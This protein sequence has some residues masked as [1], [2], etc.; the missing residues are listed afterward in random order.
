MILVFGTLCLDRVR[1]IA[2][3]PQQGGY[4]EVYDEEVLLG[5]EAANTSNALNQ[6]NANFSLVGNVLGEGDYADL[7]LKKIV[8]KGLPT[9]QL[10]L[11]P[12]VTPLCDIYV[13]PDGDRT[14]F[15]VGFESLSATN[16]LEA[17]PYEADGWFTVDMN[18]GDAGR[19]AVCQARAA[20]MKIYLMDFLRPDD[21]IDEHTYWQSSTDWAGVRGNTQKNVAYVQ[22]LVAE[23]GCFA[24]LSD[25]P[26]G[27]VAGSPEIKVRHY[28]PYPTVSYVDST[29]AGDVFRGGML[30]G[31][32]QG[33]P[34]QKCLQFASAA[35]CLK[36][37]FLGA[38][39]FSAS[40]QEIEEH[41]ENNSEVSKRYL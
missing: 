5:G 13:T 21:P 33:W 37:Q 20:G 23:R 2:S 1:R 12:G 27:L 9:H 35:G 39:M 32:D 7:L 14:M 3:L 6:W 26:N 36:C 30:F 10:K 11:R 34:I 4:A 25:G 19:S 41:I 18:L 29:G 8:E 15:G 17:I 31:L 16:E 38:T 24:V 28:P 22:K 40:V